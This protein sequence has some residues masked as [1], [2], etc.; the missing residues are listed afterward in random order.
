MNL[1]FLYVIAGSLLL[2]EGA[3]GASPETCIVA[4]Q[5]D[6][7]TFPVELLTSEARCLLADVIDHPSTTGVIGP[8]PNPDW[9][10][11]LWLSSRPSGDDGSPHGTTGNGD[12]SDH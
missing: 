8:E 10:R 7:I 12:V 4:P 1:T 5:H 6:K 9:P 2:A 11:P 3:H